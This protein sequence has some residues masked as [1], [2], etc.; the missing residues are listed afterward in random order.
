M[1]NGLKHQAFGFKSEQGFFGAEP[2]LKI[3]LKS[4]TITLSAPIVKDCYIRDLIN[5]KC[6]YI[7]YV[8]KAKNMIRLRYYLIEHPKH[9]ICL[10]D[11]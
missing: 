4:T 7:F 9:L 5:M 10:I 3:C 11:A 1:I 2:R 6:Q 8:L